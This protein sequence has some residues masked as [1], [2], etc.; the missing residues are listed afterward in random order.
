[1]E[2]RR[3]VISATKEEWRYWHIVFEAIRMLHKPLGG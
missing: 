2:I 3:I 1:M